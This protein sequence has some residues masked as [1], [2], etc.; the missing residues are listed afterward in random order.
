M[1]IKDTVFWNVRP[2]QSLGRAVTSVFKV[3]KVLGEMNVLVEV[4]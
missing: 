2:G 4:S 3:K 1:N